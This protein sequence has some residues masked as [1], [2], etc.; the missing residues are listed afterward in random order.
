L[1]ADMAFHLAIAHAAHNEVLGNAAQLLRNLMK[2]WL[3]LK[4]RLPEV[5]RLA[6]QKHRTIYQAI[7]A[8]DVAGAQRLMWE[9]LY[10]TSAL[11]TQV[12]E[13]HNKPAKSG[14]RSGAG[15]TARSSVR[16]NQAPGNAAKTSVRPLR[17]KARPR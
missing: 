1:D 12:V 14:L 7:Y 5:P 8:R 11:V 10:E 13:G 3:D 4:L 6:M 15:N 17:S 9:H 2:Y 16:K